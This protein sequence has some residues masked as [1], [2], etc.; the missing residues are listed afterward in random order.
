MNKI[1]VKV[2]LFKF[3]SQ[4]MPVCQNYTT[5]KISFFVCCAYYGCCHTYLFYKISNYSYFS[6]NVFYF[7]I[8]LSLLVAQ[9]QYSIGKSVYHFVRLSWFYALRVFNSPDIKNEKKV[10]KYNLKVSIYKIRKML[11]FH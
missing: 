1:V 6:Q 2:S 4:N 7:L 9:L 11:T 10:F 5:D 3:C 8:M